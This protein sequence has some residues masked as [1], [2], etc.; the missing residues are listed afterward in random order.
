M[1]SPRAGENMGTVFVTNPRPMTT[2]NPLL[3]HTPTSYAGKALRLINLLVIHCSATPSGKTLTTPGQT[4]ANV[5]DGWHSQRGFKRKHAA[6]THFSPRLR[7][8]GYHWVIGLDGVIL[9][10]RHPAEVGAHAAGFNANSL[11]VCLVGGLERHA[12]YTPA[13]WRS[14]ELLVRAASEA[15]RI[16]LKPPTRSYSNAQAY[17]ESNGI[18]GH[19]DLSPDK[20]GDGLIEP[21]EWLKTC[22]GFDVSHWLKNGLVPDSQNVFKG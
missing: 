15:Y 18:C 20:D 19:R 11:G 13:Q 2:N 5:I 8:I 16:P 12:Q 7:S 4:C 17:T 21:F 6:A 22:P 14:L 10:G 1:G 9:P 3:G